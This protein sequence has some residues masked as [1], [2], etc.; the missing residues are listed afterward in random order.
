[1]KDYS[2]KDMPKY[3]VALL[4][5]NAL[6][7][8]EQEYQKNKK[9]ISHKNFVLLRQACWLE[10]Y[11]IID[12]VLSFGG[13]NAIKDEEFQKDLESLKNYNS[14]VYDYLYKKIKMYEN[15][16][17]LNHKLKDKEINDE[18]QKI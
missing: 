11:E 16:F 9:I 18:I 8:I 6:P 13:Y 1:M 4:Q 3:L 15:F 14:K 17:Y 5:E 7:I 2:H 10:K 12:F